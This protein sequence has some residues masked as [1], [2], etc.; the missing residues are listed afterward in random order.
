MLAR[1][2][3]LALI[4]WALLGISD[5][6][7]L[8][9]INASDSCKGSNAQIPEPWT[10]WARTPVAVTAARSS[11]TQATIAAGIKAAVTLAPADAVRMAVTTPDG[12][13]R[14]NAHGGML[15]FYVPND[16]TYWVTVGDDLWV[17]VVQANAILMEMDERHGPPCSGIT[18][19]LQYKLRAGEARI[20]LSD[21]A[22]ARVDILVTRRP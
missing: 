11:A 19:S 22:A 10:A 9:Q 15:S 20:Q 18:K 7:T 16:G 5:M 6:Q 13:H 2:V 14:P 12:N 3:R 4:A 17:D 21:S 8:A 1:H